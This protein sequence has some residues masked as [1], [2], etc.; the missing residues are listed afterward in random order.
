MIILSGDVEAS[1]TWLQHNCEPWDDLKYN[2]KITTIRRYNSLLVDNETEPISAYFSK[3]IVLTHSLG[4]CLIDIDFAQL[5]K[6]V[7][8]FDKWD[9]FFSRVFQICSTKLFEK[10]AKELLEL[11]KT[12]QISNRKTSLI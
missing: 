9:N 8:I 11:L 12:E 7:N 1:M 2:W 10:D 3:Y 5:Y 4:H 6:N